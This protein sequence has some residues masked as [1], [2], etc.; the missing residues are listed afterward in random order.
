MSDVTTVESVKFR[1]GTTFS[2]VFP[3]LPSLTVEPRRADLYQEQ[4]SHDIL[5]LQY[6]SESPLWFQSIKTGVPVEFSW[7]QDTLSQ[8]FYGYVSSISKV[9]SANR[10]DFMEI[11]CVGTTYR[12]KER[13]T[14]VFKN[15][16]IPQAV[17]E[18]VEAYGFSF[19]GEDDPQTFPQLV[20]AGS[21]YWEWIQEQARRIGFGVV[22]EG[23]TFFFKPLDRLIDL[24][25]SNAAILSM[26]D[27]LT[28]F[29]TQFL[30]R[31]LDYFKVISGSNVEDTNDVRAVKNVGG[32]DPITG[33]AFAGAASPDEVGANL[34]TNVADVL[35][36]EYRTDRVLNA[37]KSAESAADGLAQLARFNIPARVQCQGDPRIR[38]FGSVFING[39]GALTDGFWVVRRAHHMF[40]KV[41]DYVMELL[42]ATDGLGAGRQSGFRTR[43]TSLTG[44]VNL[45]DAVTS[46]TSEVIRLGLSRPR[47]TYTQQVVQEN[48]QGFSTNPILWK[49]VEV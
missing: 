29:N 25:F 42:V 30:D 16:T 34:R 20:I 9:N 1:K 18:I 10:L 37:S 36:Q 28:P 7:R 38:P 47:L 19:V 14:H 2:A 13:A 26:G 3:S 39:T 22:V 15:V 33:K 6:P 43:G 41:G 23:T 45:E 5:V 8:S 24:G 32:V 31:T 49:S 12:L 44:T 11:T 46:A 48:N 40:H 27:Q 35:F 4:N 21:S 17:R